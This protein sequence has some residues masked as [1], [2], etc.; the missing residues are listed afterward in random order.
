M[1]RDRHAAVAKLLH[2]GRQGAVWRPTL[3]RVTATTAHEDAERRIRAIVE[4]AGL[5]PP[6]EVEYRRDEIVLLWHETK[7]AVIVELGDLEP[8]A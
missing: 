6:D 5:S 2:C 4:E 8:A 3:V 7:L 1:L